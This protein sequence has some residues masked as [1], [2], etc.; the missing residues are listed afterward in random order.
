MVIFIMFIIVI[1]GFRPTWNDYFKT[2]LHTTL[3]VIFIST[4]NY[5]LD[6]NYMFTRSKPPGTTFAELMPGWPYYFIIMLLIGLAF[7][8]F[9]MIVSFITGTTK[10]RL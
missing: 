8:T 4:I 10:K 7:Y 3:L 2:I 1:D 9:L 5:L 6:S